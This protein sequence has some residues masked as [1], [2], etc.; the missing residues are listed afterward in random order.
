[1]NEH[2]FTTFFLT[3]YWIEFIFQVKLSQVLHAIVDHDVIDLL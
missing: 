1:M 2:I 3:W